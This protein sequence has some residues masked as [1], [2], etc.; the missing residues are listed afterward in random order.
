MVSMQRIG[1]LGNQIP[2]CAG[3]FGPSTPPAGLGLS[4]GDH[5]PGHDVVNPFATVT[6][7]GGALLVGGVL[8]VGGLLLVAVFRRK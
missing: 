4:L 1:G 6:S 5:I 2:A 8:L 7:T 3:C